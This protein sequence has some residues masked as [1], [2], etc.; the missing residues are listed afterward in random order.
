MPS[1]LIFD[2]KRYAINDGPG[3]RVTIFL[4]GCPLSCVWCHN[5]ESIS[6]KHQ[7]MYDANKCIGC[8]ECVKACPQ[9]ALELTEEGI[10]T[11]SEAC[12]LCGICAEVC[13][14]KAIEMSGCVVTVEG[15]L[16]IIERERVFFDNSGGG[17]TISGGEP[18]LHAEFTLKLLQ[19]CGKRS[20]HRVVDTTGFAKRDILLKIAKETDL[21]LYDLKHMD[22]KEHK[23]WTGV[24]NKLILENLNTLAEIGANIVI[25][26]PF[27]NGVNTDEVNVRE[28]AKFISSLSGAPKLVNLLPFH[29][30]AQ[31]KHEK[32]G[33][34]CELNSMTAPTEKE[35]ADAIT[36][37]S[38]YGL[39]AKI[40]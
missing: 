25:R 31:K 5:P 7:K 2:I 38:E 30:I 28:T 17:V 12:D 35:L 27:I 34:S 21:F 13:P 1:S 15:L 8:S 10:V 23:K 3:I 11:D 6:L 22:A 37:F 26:I 4:K 32:L 40:G 9:G 36:I 33:Q 14:T 29:N 16:E 18:L 24:D 39:V 20:I 19:E